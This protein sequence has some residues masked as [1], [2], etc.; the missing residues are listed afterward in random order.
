MS[1]LIIENF[2]NFYL[3]AHGEVNG[4]IGKLA[5]SDPTNVVAI[6]LG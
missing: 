4:K 1:Y 2:I 3:I 5:S 6:R